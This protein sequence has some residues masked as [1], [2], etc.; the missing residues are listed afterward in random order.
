[1]MCARLNQNMRRHARAQCLV[2]GREGVQK[3][4]LFSLR[5]MKYAHHRP[6]LKW[7]KKE[8]C[9][10]WFASKNLLVLLRA[11]AQ[12]LLLP[13]GI[14]EAKTTL[15]Y[16]G[17]FNSK[18]F[19]LKSSERGRLWNCCHNYSTIGVWKRV[20]SMPFTQWSSCIGKKRFALWRE[21]FQC[22]G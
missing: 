6:S 11:P 3:N 12:E 7:G 21:L 2:M 15:L 13:Y 18:Y 8:I 20:P 19:K 14:S 22:G 17:T 4:H 10:F 16:Y 5:H 9:L 1:M